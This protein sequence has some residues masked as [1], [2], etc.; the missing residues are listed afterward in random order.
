L[1]QARATEVAKLGLL[2]KTTVQITVFCPHPSDDI[3]NWATEGLLKLESRT[4]RSDDIIGG[5]LF[6][7]ANEQA[8][9]NSR[10]AALAKTEG[11]LIN[12]VNNLADS[13]FITPAIVE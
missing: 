10:T 7:G 8:E 13:D 9:E 3:L 1:C 2:I 6:S 11:A 12:I 5:R 4:L